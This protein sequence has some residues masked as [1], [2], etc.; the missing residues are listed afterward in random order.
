MSHVI[1]KEDLQGTTMIKGSDIELHY[2]NLKLK[3][4]SLANT[5]K[6]ISDH[7]FITVFLASLPD[8]F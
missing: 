8:S 6:A 2:Q 4:L 3:C 1:F 5:R 7:N